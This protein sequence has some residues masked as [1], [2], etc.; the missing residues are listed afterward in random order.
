M[1]NIQPQKIASIIFALAFVQVLG[2]IA[3]QLLGSKVGAVLAGFFGGLLSSTATTASLARKSKD[4]SPNKTS[5]EI[6]TFLSATLAMLFEG[7]IVIFW[8]IKEIH[9]PL[10]LIFSGPVLVTLMS[11]F[12]L[13]RKANE[14]YLKTENSPL[15]IFPILKL[16]VFIIA[17]LLISKFL[18]KL[19]GQSGLLVFTFIVSL[20]EIH[21]S[22]IANI[23]LHDAGTFNVQ[24]LGSLLAISVA[25]SY[26]SKLFLIATLGSVHLKF[27]S[28]KYMSILF[29]SLIVSWLV[30]LI[31]V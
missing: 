8:G 2:F 25:A 10:F 27:Q 22:L 11:I 30:F 20:F 28:I 23:Q 6:L 15:E 5:T 24:L 14:G 3:S 21:G 31:F 16:S 29:L 13:S 12:I 19:F 1:E 26:L 17:I 4:S 7:I 18:Q 9:Y